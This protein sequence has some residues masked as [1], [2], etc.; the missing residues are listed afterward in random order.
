VSEKQ[1]N[2]V[3]VLS[4]IGELECRA[5]DVEKVLAISL[6]LILGCFDVELHTVGGLSY[7]CNRLGN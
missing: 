1:R 2:S 4:L 3:R 7:K 6:L 5:C